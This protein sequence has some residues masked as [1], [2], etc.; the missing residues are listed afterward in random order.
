MGSERLP[1]KMLLPLGDKT[2]FE[3]VIQRIK[4]CQNNNIVLATGENIENDVLV[5]LAAKLNIDVYRGSEHDVLDRYL[6]AA[7][8]FQADVVIRITGDCHL[9][10][11][12]IIDLSTA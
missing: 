12:E 7:E 8:M 5:N 11:P 1:G 6:K 3:V 9:I 4:Q 10:D 2:L